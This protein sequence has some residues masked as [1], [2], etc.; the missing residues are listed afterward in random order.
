VREEGVDELAAAVGHDMLARLRLQCAHRLEGAACVRYVRRPSR[1]ASVSCI[2]AA[3][4]APMSS[5]Q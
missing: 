2:I 4:L 5:C 3:K 1:N